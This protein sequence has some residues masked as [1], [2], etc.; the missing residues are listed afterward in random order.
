MCLYKVDKQYTGCSLKT[1]ELLDCMLIDVCAVIR[2]NM[3]RYLYYF[4]Q[5]PVELE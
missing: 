3:I 4:N 5:C 2:L 1:T